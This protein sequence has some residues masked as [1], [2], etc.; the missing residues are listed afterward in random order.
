MVIEVVPDKLDS[1]GEPNSYRIQAIPVY[2]RGR[3]KFTHTPYCIVSLI[4]FSLVL[5]TLY[6]SVQK[7][8]NIH[9]QN[10]KIIIQL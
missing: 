10:I 5:K 4:T 2:L 6:L 1:C 8:K 3:V 9:K 7:D